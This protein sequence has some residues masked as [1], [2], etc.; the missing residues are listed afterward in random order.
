MEE[1]RITVGVCDCYR[2][3]RGRMNG[4]YRPN[5]TFLTGGFTARPEGDAVVLGDELGREIHRGSEIRLAAERDAT[6]TLLDVTIGVRFHW[7]R[8]EEQTFSGNLILRAAGEGRVTAINELPLEEYLASV[9]SSEMSGEAPA[10]FLKAHAIASRSWLVAML[11]RKGREG[12]KGGAAAGT[13]RRDG[14]IVR[15]YDREDHDR[16]DVCADDHCQRYQGI[17]RLAAGRAAEAVRATRGVFLIRDDEVCDARYHK[18]CGGMTEEYA[19][20]WEERTVSYLSHV[21]DAARPLEPV[22]TEADAERWI[23][24]CPDV[25]CHTQDT[26]LLKKILPSF[27]R[28]TVDFFRWQVGYAREELEAILREKSGIDFGSLTSITP[29]ERGPSGRISRL[30]IAGS[31]DTAIV[32]K[33]LEIRRWLSPSH[34]MSSAFI[35]AATPGPSGVPTRFTF[36]G[37]GWGHGVGLCQI[38]AAVMADKGFTA[39]EILRHYFRG[40]ALV[41]RY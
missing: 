4:M 5:G 35:V 9:V 21:S 14:E 17:T 20:C 32:G 30:R 40:A 31:K 23:L 16:F 38:G 7:E 12:G 24:S 6:F 34:L 13:I 2:T 28:E 19:T 36:Y 10:E 18:A 25:Y 27:D 29:L 37:A 11:R 3:I 15:W 26:D 1:P 22:R 39:E 41:K 8:H 33:E